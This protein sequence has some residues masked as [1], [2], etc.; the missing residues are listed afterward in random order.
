MGGEE[1]G[2]ETEAILVQIGRRF[3]GCPHFAGA[4]W[5]GLRA[6]PN[7]EG[8]PPEKPPRQEK[9]PSTSPALVKLDFLIGT[10]WGSNVREEAK[11]PIP[12]PEEEAE[13]P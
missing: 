1:L 8:C 11:A 13:R 6:D 4:G 9:A 5:P 12:E 2:R 7:S 10:K 3:L